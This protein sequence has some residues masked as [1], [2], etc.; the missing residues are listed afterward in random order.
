MKILA[1]HA[2]KLEKHGYSILWHYSGIY[3]SSYYIPTSN[4]NPYM[5]NGI[6]L[7]L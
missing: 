1:G 6:R 7:T 2:H 3:Y 5:D 4:G